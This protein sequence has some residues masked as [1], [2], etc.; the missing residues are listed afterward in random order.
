MVA[1]I[2]VAV[3]IGISHFDI[4]IIPESI[5][6]NDFDLWR[7]IFRVKWQERNARFL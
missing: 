4:V 5:A 1:D 2:V 7:D 6:D 3:F